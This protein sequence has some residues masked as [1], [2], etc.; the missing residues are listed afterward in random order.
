MSKT[1]EK[2]STEEQKPSLIGGVSGCTFD[3]AKT[4]HQI[5]HK[6][7][8]WIVKTFGKDLHGEW[9]IMEGIGANGKK[10]KIK[11]R[12][13]YLSMKYTIPNV[14]VPE[15]TEDEYWDMKSKEKEVIPLK[16]TC[17]DCAITT[18]FYIEMADSLKK[19][20][21]D[22]QEKVSKTWFCHNSCHR[23]CAGI[24]L[25]LQT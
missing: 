24:R 7:S 8:N 2:V 18:G 6:F 10:F 25:Y 21:K 14:V 20:P 1:D 19:Q 13:F 4:P 5:W 15:I 23:G 3:S 22:I 9:Q 11:H 16:K 12:F 17:I